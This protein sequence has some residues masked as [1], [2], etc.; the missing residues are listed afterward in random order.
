MAFKIT[1]ALISR[2]R[3][4]AAESVE[5]NGLPVPRGKNDDPTFF[6]MPHGAAADERFGK[7]RNVN[8]GQ[9]A[10]LNAGFLQSILKHNRVH[11]GRQHADIIGGGAVH[12]AGALRDSAKNVSAAN[13]N[14]DLSAELVDL[15]DFFG[16]RR[17]RR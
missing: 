13:N 14:C 12:V 15:L 3:S 8:R 16:D 2:A 11:Y 1:S 9:D 17:A 5:K 10:S 7:L 4:A 6:Q